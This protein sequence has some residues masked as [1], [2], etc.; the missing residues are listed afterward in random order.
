MAEA[1]Q[2]QRQRQKAATREA[3]KRSA[4]ACFATQGYDATSI[5]AI[6]RRCGVATGTFYVHFSTK[7]ALLAEL[8][9]D[10]NAG[11][12]AALVPIWRDVDLAAAGSL[13][14]PVRDSAKAFLGY[15]QAHRGFVESYARAFAP[16]LEELAGGI[17]PPAQHFLAQQLLRRSPGLDRRAATLTVHGLLAMWA[18][19]ALQVLFRPDIDEAVAVDTLSRLTLGLLVS[20]DD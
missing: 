4:T 5:T 7:E 20:I 6:T 3:L 10:F 17:N 14:M 9:A 15:W 18:R 13:E 11:L 19:I 12:M 8:L 2:T 16:R 1:V